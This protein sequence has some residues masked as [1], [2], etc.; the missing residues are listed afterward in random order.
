M[1]MQSRADPLCYMCPSM[2]SGQP[3]DGSWTGKTHKPLTLHPNSESH[4]CW[5]H[6]IV[7]ESNRVYC[8]V[9]WREGKGREPM[10]SIC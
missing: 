10:V 7:I 5:P 9:Q 3:R 4:F 8:S 1:N 6:S 2:Q